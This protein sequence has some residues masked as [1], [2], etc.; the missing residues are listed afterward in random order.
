MNTLI[1]SF[2]AFSAIVFALTLLMNLGRKNSW[3]VVYYLLQ[4]LVVTIGLISLSFSEGAEGLF[5][6]ALL[7][8]T[9]KVIL[10]PAFLLHMIQKY[11]IYF[12]GRSYLNTPFTLFCL[13]A[14]TAFSYSLIGPHV[15]EFGHSVGITLLF[16]AIL[17]VLFQMTNRSGTLSAII[18]ILSLENAVVLLTAQLGLEHSFALEFAITFDIAVWIGI[19]TGFLTMIYREFGT[20]DTAARM[21]HLIEE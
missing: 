16:A 2:G 7:T 18:G 9:V 10:A 21:T 19:A 14:I 20:V 15:S 6:A 17:C 8:L 13:A 1:Q 11:R 4:S 3:L 12:S 5:Y